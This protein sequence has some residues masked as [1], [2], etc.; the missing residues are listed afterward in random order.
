MLIVHLI[1]TSSL[2][3][4]VN[5]LRRYIDTSEIFEMT[6]RRTNV[7][8]DALRR[9]DRVTFSPNNLF[10]NNLIIFRSGG[11]RNVLRLF[12]PRAYVYILYIYLSGF[13]ISSLLVVCDKRIRPMKLRI[14]LT[15]RVTRK[16]VT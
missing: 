6:I 1:W 8:N 15:H 9:M 7:L 2:K 14:K 10:I 4:A 3:D 16:C 11:Q 13:E 12:W 5:F